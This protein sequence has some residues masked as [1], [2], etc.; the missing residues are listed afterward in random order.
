MLFEFLENGARVEPNGAPGEPNGALA[1]P[2]GAQG[3]QNGAPAEPDGAQG[4]QNGAPTGAF[5]GTRTH[6]LTHSHTPMFS[7][8]LP[9]THTHTDAFVP[10]L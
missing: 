6:S 9:R 7:H 1:E 4:V 2:D 5:D 10:Q 3:V 8:A